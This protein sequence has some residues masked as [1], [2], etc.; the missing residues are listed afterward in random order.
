MEVKNLSCKR[1]GCPCQNSKRSGL[2]LYP[3]QYLGF[4]IKLLHKEKRKD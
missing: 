3:P 1:D 4:G 2:S